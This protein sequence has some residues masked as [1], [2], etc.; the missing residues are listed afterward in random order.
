MSSPQMIKMFGLSLTRW[1]FA[2]EARKLLQ[3]DAADTGASF[4]TPAGRTLDPIPVS[5]VNSWRVARERVAARRGKPPKAP[6]M[7]SQ[8]DGSNHSEPKIVT[9]IGNS[10]RKENSMIWLMLL[11]TT[12]EAPFFVA[13]ASWWNRRHP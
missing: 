10:R 1:P 2:V 6:N 4:W 13:A 11:V 8:P 5:S 9:T 3:P 7:G 12:I